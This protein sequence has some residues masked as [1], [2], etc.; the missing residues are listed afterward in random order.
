MAIREYVGARYVPRFTGL[1]DATQIYD[2]LDV[3]DNGSGTSYIAKKTVPA[4]TALTNTDY[5]FVYGAS[6]GAILDL[7]NRMNN[8][9]ETTDLLN[10]KN[11]I[12]ISD[13][14]GIDAY[15][16]GTS[17][18]TF[19]ESA[20]PD[21]NITKY[22]H[23]GG[24]FGYDPSD[25][26]YFPTFLNTLTEDPDAD[27]V[28]FLAGANDGNL[29]W[30]NQTTVAAVK[31]GIAAGVSI[32]R[33]KFPNAEIHFGFVG[34]YKYSS[35]FLNYKTA[36]IAYLEAAHENAVVFADNFQYILHSKSVIDNGDVHP[37]LIGSKL[38]SYYAIQYIKTNTFSVIEYSNEAEGTGNVK[39][40]FRFNIQRENGICVMTP[41]VNGS[42]ALEI[43]GM[44]K[45]VSDS[46][47]FVDFA[48]DISSDTFNSISI[49]SAACA[50]SLAYTDGGGVPNNPYITTGNIYFASDKM[51][52]T[53]YK[54][55]GQHGGT[56]TAL[57]ATL[58]AIVYNT[59]DC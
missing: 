2:A 47:T 16:G 19:V 27:M 32:L 44:S 5:W 14:Y 13:S 11:I 30:Y 55:W 52:L 28:L 40:G 3:V 56:Y 42:N 25:S 35:H 23:G 10:R 36:F 29:F 38:I 7:Q 37:S 41:N 31:S 43:T 50:L 4:G 20:F 54:P 1:Y 24:G 12:L 9:E 34:R 48:F 15:C 18:E 45:T 22:A 33:S 21:K 58:P 8:V 6:S 57:V 46:S 53:F 49:N 59:L 17:W 39:S 26:R 51:H